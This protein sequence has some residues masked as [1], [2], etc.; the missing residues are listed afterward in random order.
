MIDLISAGLM[1]LQ[2]VLSLDFGKAAASPPAARYYEEIVAE[3][4]WDVRSGRQIGSIGHS[5]A[6]F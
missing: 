2:A 3:L 6:P 5:H 4:G 1:V